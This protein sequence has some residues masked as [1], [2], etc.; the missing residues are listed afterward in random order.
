M[1]DLTP[2]TASQE[3]FQLFDTV[4]LFFNEKPWSS[5]AVSFILWQQHFSLLT[6]DLCTL[7]LIFHVV[8]GGGRSG[9]F[10]PQDPAGGG[11][12]GPCSGE[13]GYSLAETGGGREE[14]R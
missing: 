12:V 3:S 8:A 4:L 14:C 13:T 11:G 6:S 5:Q 9:V 10:E 7:L 1:E 2:K